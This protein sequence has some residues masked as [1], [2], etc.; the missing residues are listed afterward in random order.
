MQDQKLLEENIEVKLHNIALDNYLFWF[1]FRSAGNK[2][3]NRP[4]WD[5]IK[6]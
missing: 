2:S 3:K 1:D 5:Y 4:K 6:L